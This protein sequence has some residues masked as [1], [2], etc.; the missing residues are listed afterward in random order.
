M[1]SRDPYDSIDE[2]VPLA[3]NPN[4]GLS[5]AGDGERATHSSDGEIVD[6]PSDLVDLDK[7]I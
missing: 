6:M 1:A 5:D 2:Q 3:N 7:V 4:S